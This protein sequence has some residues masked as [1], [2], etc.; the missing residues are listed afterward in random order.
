MKAESF[1][2]KMFFFSFALFKVYG[3]GENQMVALVIMF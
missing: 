1:V 2:P 3:Y